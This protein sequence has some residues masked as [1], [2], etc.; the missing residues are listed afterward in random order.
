MDLIHVLIKATSGPITGQGRQRGDT[1]SVKVE[2]DRV[3]S[4]FGQ[5]DMIP[6][7][8][9]MSTD[10]EGLAI[11]QEPK[12]RGDRRWSVDLN[13]LPDKYLSEFVAGETVYIPWDELM[14]HIEAR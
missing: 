1:I 9:R 10:I 14:N 13:Q 3:S 7:A 11:L 8:Y 12:E 5:S 6:Y 4:P 2:S